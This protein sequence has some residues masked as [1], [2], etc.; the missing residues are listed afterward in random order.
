MFLIAET[1]PVGSDEFQRVFDIAAE[2]YPDSDIANINAAA[3]A[4]AAKDTEAAQKFLEKVAK[5]D[6]AAYLNNL[7]M[8]AA[9]Q[10]DREQAACHFRKA[11][12]AGNA[13]AGKNLAEI[14]KK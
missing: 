8:I 5:H 7:G 3:T 14:E 4:L 6:D 10:D 11:M 9:M 12:E 2:T 13:E 1:Y